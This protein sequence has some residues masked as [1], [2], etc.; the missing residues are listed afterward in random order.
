MQHTFHLGQLVLHEHERQV[1]V[2]GAVAGV[3]GEREGHVG[4]RVQRGGQQLVRRRRRAAPRRAHAQLA[5]VRGHVRRAAAGHAHLH[6]YQISTATLQSSSL[7]RILT[8]LTKWLRSPRTHCERSVACLIASYKRIVYF[9][10][11]KKKKK[12]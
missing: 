8:A 5:H 11:V 1:A 4:A 7:N 6:T 2:A 3:G 12:K 9:L 10:Q